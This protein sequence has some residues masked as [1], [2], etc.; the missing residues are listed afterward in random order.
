MAKR[1]AL[2]YT[3]AV[4]VLL[5]F[6]GIVSAQDRFWVREIP[7]PE[8]ENSAQEVANLVVIRG[9][10]VLHDWESEKGYVRYHVRA[11][12]SFGRLYDLTAIVYNDGRRELKI[13]FYLTNYEFVGRDADEMVADQ[14]I[15][16][17]PKIHQEIHIWDYGVDETVDLYQMFSKQRGS[18]WGGFTREERD[19]GS[20]AGV[21]EYLY[22]HGEV[23]RERR[24][25]WDGWSKASQWE[26]EDI[27]DG[28]REHLEDL[29]Y[30]LTK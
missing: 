26:E 3:L 29:I 10:P 7:F 15:W 24:F 6:S 12:T 18:V 11:F 25:W 23:Y 13:Y 5:G 17:P 9:F 19:L 28:Y 16:G 20:K 22:D 27:Q 21:K 30:L 8:P 1:T 2:L 4:S 14:L